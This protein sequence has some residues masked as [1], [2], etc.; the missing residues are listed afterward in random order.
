MIDQKLK[1]KI[2][3]LRSQKEYKLKLIR[4]IRRDNAYKRQQEEIERAELVFNKTP[5]YEGQKI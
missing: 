5:K 3:Q 2:H 4:A 1:I